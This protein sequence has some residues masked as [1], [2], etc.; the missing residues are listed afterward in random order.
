MPTAIVFVSS[1]G[2]C[3]RQLLP[4]FDVSERR[5][6]GVRR[7]ERL[8]VPAE[9]YGVIVDELG[10]ATVTRE[11]ANVTRAAAVSAAALVW[12]L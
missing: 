3:W 12:M 2:C 6:N 8:G 7:V 9:L 10:G 5:Y 1:R 11:L 4:V